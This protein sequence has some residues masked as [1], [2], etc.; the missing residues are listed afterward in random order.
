MPIY[1]NRVNAENRVALGGDVSSLVATRR[2]AVIDMMLDGL[3]LSHG[4]A[5]GIDGW[6][7][8]DWAGLTDIIAAAV[9]ERGGTTEVVDA[10]R[11]FVDQIAIDEYRAKFLTDDPGFGWVNSAGQ[12]SDIIDSDAVATV[13]RE[14][15]QLK[16]DGRVV[17]LSGNGAVLPELRSLYDRIVY[18]EMT[19][20]PMM[21]Q[22]WEGALKPFGRREPKTDYW[23]KEYYYCDFYLL[24]DHRKY[25]QSEMDLFLEAIDLN[26]LKLVKRKAFDEMLDRLSQQPI[27]EIKIFSPGPWGAYRFKD[28]VDVPGLGCNAW[29][30]L[31]SP[32]LGILVEVA[33]E[34]KI[35]MQFLELMRH[36]DRIV[37]DRIAKN[38]PDLFPV[39][40]FLDDGFFPEP[41]PAERT[42]MPMHN[43][44]DSDY[45]R[46]HFNEQMGRY[47][48]Y[49]IAEAYEGSSTW[50]GF[51]DDADLEEWE[52]RCF[53]SWKTGEPIE[54]WKDYI[55]NWTTN[56]GDL[57][58]IPPGITHGHGGNQMVLEMDT[59]P[60]ISATEYSFFGY[61]FVRNTW[62]DTTKTMTGPP[63]KM[64]MEH[65]VDNERGY[66]ASY[67]DKQL[68]PRPEVFAFHKNYWLD[69]YEAP[70]S[71][72][73]LVERLHFKGAGEYTTAGRFMH[74]AT[75][76][77]GTRVRIYPKSDPSKVTEVDFLQSTIIPAC[78]GDYVVE[79]TEAGLCTLV[80][81]RFQE[82]IA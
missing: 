43:H 66:R 39:E 31:A 15:E 32:D 75:L 76:T 19:V 55:A 35:E 57:F 58:Y 56:V 80:I 37:G 46:R 44:P 50:M 26:E 10:T 47:E 73:F 23:W 82:G 52:L 36:Q 74:V 81:M 64:H 33:P 63:M 49:Y 70:G 24:H 48:T 53:E 27:K 65:Y 4:A 54:D 42:S 71:M 72:P 40:I 62:D 51:A 2:E 77:V 59:C 61:D 3:D 25:V 11:L 38:H 6:Y 68:R 78:L 13:R 60:S 1:E 12:I 18:V 8:V 41:Q 45:V 67:V 20:E 22:M 69:R 9:T 17:V 29:N 7:G 34:V 5:L 16:K 79:S 21:W 30:R 28:Y 14:I